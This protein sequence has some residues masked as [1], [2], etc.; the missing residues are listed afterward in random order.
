MRINIVSRCW[1][2]VI[3]TIS[4]LVPSLVVLINRLLRLI[5]SCSIHPTLPEPLFLAATYFFPQVN[6]ELVVRINRSFIYYSWRDDV[7]G[8]R[9]WHLPGGIIRPNESIQSRVQ[10]VLLSEVN[11]PNILN[12]TTLQYVGF[13]EVFS[14]SSPCIRSHFLSHLYPHPIFTK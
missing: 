10:Q 14:P 6:V 4:L 5:T 11:L 1:K 7:F 12:Y 13:S 2:N 9:G 3:Y 8:N